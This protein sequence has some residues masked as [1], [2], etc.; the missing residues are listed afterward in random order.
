M[1]FTFTESDKQ[2]M[3]EEMRLEGYDLTA[4]RIRAQVIAEAKF[5]G[6]VF[7]VQVG[8]IDQCEW[9]KWRGQP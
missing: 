4:G 7:M 5:T 9:D 6:P 3:K 8:Q 1:N 2:R